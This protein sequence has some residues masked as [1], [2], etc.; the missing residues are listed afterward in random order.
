MPD[1][2]TTRTLIRWKQEG[3]RIVSVTA[4]DYPT[5]RLADEVGIDVVLMGDSVGNTMLG[6]ETRIALCVVV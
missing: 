6:Y 3:H 2:V 5:A 4:Y 1:K